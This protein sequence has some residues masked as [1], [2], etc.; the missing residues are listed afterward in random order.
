MGL[1]FS[2]QSSL[3]ALALPASRLLLEVEEDE[4]EGEAEEKRRG[5]GSEG[6]AEE[7]YRARAMQVV[8]AMEMAE[9]AASLSTPHEQQVQSQQR[10]Q[11]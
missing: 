1:D 5:S 7:A 11:R 10:W 9:L 6:G 3:I 8:E 4:D 2:L